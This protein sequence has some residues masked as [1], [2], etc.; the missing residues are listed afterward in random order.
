MLINYESGDKMMID[1]IG[2]VE[3]VNVRLEK[4]H[5]RFENSVTLTSKRTFEIFNRSKHMVLDSSI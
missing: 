5:L 1:L 3:N 4:S 2:T